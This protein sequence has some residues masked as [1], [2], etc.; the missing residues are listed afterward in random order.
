[1]NSRLLHRAIG[2]LAC[3]AMVS[4]ASAAD[5]AE[6]RITDTDGVA[7][8]KV[9]FQ[10]APAGVLVSVDVTGLP[11]GGHGIHLHAVGSCS[12]DFKASA[13]HI[14]PEGV[15]HGLLNPSGGDNGDLPNL[16]AA[17]DGSARA[18]FFTT[19]VSLKGAD[20]PALLDADGSAVIIHD[21]PDDHLTQPIGGAGGR[22]ACGVI[23][24][25]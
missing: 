5:M 14:N 21:K 15:A 22:I 18:E 2:A 19:R 3:L 7:I 23:E 17:A 25:M 12:P 16:Y 8:G 6:A 1:M 13:G 10:Q 9:T 11:P 24:G 4:G 20:L